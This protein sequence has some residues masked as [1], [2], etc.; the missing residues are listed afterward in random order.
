MGK[1][2][3]GNISKGVYILHNGQPHYVAKTQFVSPGK[4]SAFTRARLQNLKTGST[5]EF[6]FKSHDAVEEIEVES[7]EMQ[8]L[9]LGGDEANFMDPR[10]YEQ[11]SIPVE[12]MDGKEKFLVPELKVY[13]QFYQD[14]PIGINLP[15]KVEMTVEQAEEAVAGDRQNA[16]KKSVTMETGLTVQVP[17]FIKKGDRL[18]IDVDSGTYVSR[19]N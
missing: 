15:A 8:F 3:A 5:V 1:L 16:G 18:I 9:Y 11:I 6:V 4:G 10:S 19:A 13:A 17:L 2:K 12:L 7:K 14:K